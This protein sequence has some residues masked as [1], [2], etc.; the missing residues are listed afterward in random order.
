MRAG[1]LSRPVNMSAATAPTAPYSPGSFAW[2]Q[3]GPTGRSARRST[4]EGA[5]QPSRAVRT[6]EPWTHPR[7][8]TR[9]RSMRRVLAAGLLAAVLATQAWAWGEK[10]HKTA[11][12]IP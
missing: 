2:I 3:Y 1:F 12:P 9:R 8:F 6:G 4:H 10:G 5:G 7:G 11:A